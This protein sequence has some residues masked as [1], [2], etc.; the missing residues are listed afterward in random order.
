MRE[1]S[2]ENGGLPL[3]SIVMVAETPRIVQEGGAGC[4]VLEEVADYL[5]CKETGREESKPVVGPLF[6]I[7]QLNSSYTVVQDVVVAT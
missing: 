5:Q 7:I 4:V 3:F 6:Y 1:N 2:L